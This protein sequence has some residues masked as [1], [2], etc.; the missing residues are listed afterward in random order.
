N[1]RCAR[2]REALKYLEAKNYELEI[3]KYITEGITEKEVGELIEK[4]GLQPLELV[5]TQDKIYRE[6]YKGKTLTHGQWA[7][8]LAEN[9]GML[10]R[11]LV[12]NGNRAVLAIPPETVE[13]IM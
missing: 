13:S 12:V 3:R 8:V 9:P 1:P 10:Q 7:R 2:S 5:R 11:P 4:T 6:K